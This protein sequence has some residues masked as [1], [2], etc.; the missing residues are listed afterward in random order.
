[1]SRILERTRADPRMPGG[2]DLLNRLV[3]QTL[4]EPHD[5]IRPP[6]P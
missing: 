5:M 3:D 6:D 4:L 1:M 2:V